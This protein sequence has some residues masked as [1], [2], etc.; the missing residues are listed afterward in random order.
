MTGAQVLLNSLVKNNINTIFGYPGGAIMPIYDAL[1]KTPELRHILVRHEQGAIHA[2]EGYARYTNTIGVCFATS[3][4]G[5]TNLVTGLV[6]AMMDSVPIIAITG[7]VF[8]DLIGL[9]AFQE[10]DIVGITAVTTKY[11]FLIREPELIEDAVYEAIKIATSNRPGPVLIDISKDAQSDEIKS[12]KTV[13]HIPM[14]T[15]TIPK[16]TDIKDAAEI[17]NNSKNPL[18]L[19]GHGIRISETYKDLL[20]LAETGNIPVSCTL[21]GLSSIDEYHPLY[22]G[23]L[24]MHG[25]YAPN[26]ATEKADC[27]IALGMRFDDRVTGRL[28]GYARSAKIIHVDINDNEIGKNVKPDIS[29]HS[30]LKEF[31]KKIQPHIK[32]KER[33]EWFLKIK[34]WEE[35]ENIKVRKKEDENSELTCSYVIKRLS[36]I[37]EGKALVIADVGQNQ[38]I[39]ARY[40]KSRIPNSFFTSGG[41]GT[42][43]FALPAGIGVAIASVDKEC[44]IVVGD[45]G[46]QM[47]MQELAVIKQE[48]INVKIAIINNGYLG[49]VRQWQELFF[50]GQ[51][52]HVELKNPDFIKL[53]EAFE[54]KGETVD[55]KDKVDDAIKR[56]R[57]YPGSYIIEFKTLKE[58]A[59]FPMIE[60]GASTG[61][62]RLE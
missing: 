18:I 37:T 35:N 5:A 60:P 24:G 26:I 41:A 30:D 7:Q 4:P 27:I 38:M 61:E 59:V 46:I 42:M 29:I 62:I 14:N 28:D 23:M 47:T 31:F 36:D 32:H 40:Y 33:K 50:D 9:D 1:A 52:S 57:K 55:T 11:N 48:K 51:L 58:E 16:D 53:A 10:T 13:Y 25:N 49:M 34:D 56:A 17:I 2:A 15:K 22:I 19:A 43:G 45:G 20:N 3:G 44:W 8:S 54:I 39:A 12:K 6:D 21:H